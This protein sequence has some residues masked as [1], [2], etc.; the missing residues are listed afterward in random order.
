MKLIFISFLLLLRN[1]GC[2][3]GLTEKKKK[4]SNEIE[5]I[6]NPVNP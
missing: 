2:V 3:G 4:A 6:N 5:K 1:V